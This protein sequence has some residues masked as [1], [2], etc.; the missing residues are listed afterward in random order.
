MANVY[1]AAEKAPA[2]PAEVVH[3][4]LTRVIWQA[5]ADLSVP[6]YRQEAQEFFSGSTFAE[7]CD[8]LG[9]NV[10]RAREGLG[11]FVSS[12]ARISGNHVLPT[13]GAGATAGRFIT[14]QASA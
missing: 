3:S 11:R 4:L 8:M 5:L 9:W 14:G 10:R 13:D 7:Y 12:G 1:A 6:A 2:I